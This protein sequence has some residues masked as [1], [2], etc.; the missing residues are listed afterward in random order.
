MS[1]LAYTSLMVTVF[2]YGNSNKYY[3]ANLECENET[4]NEIEREIFKKCFGV[5]ISN[6]IK[7]YSLAA[8]LMH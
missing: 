1:A 8:K 4:I 7:M 3:N 5:K 6:L 2:W